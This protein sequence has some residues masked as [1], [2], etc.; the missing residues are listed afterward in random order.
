MLARTVRLKVYPEPVGGLGR[1][2][3]LGGVGARWLRLTHSM[4]VLDSMVQVPDLGE[5]SGRL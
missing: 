1:G 5:T 3:F 4:V 2:P